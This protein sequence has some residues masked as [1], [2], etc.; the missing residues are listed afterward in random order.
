ML[1][2]KSFLTNRKRPF[3]DVLLP[4]FDDPI[5]MAAVTGADRERFLQ[6]LN[7]I[8]AKT[9]GPDGKVNNDLANLMYQD[10]QVFLIT[11]SAV[12]ENFDPI[13][14]EKDIPE[15]KKKPYTVID[16]LYTTA[17]TVSTLTQESRD[18]IE[19]N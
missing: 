1:D 15:I 6:R 18:A 9:E 4:G 7:D 8:N 13:F 14:D 10:L 16:L 12:D 19:K 5:R 17:Q 3:K 11:L 2:R